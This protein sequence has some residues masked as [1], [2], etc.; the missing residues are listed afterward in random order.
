[1]RFGA[2]RPDLA[3]RS[4]TLPPAAQPRQRGN[5]L[6]SPV[7]SGI[8]ERSGRTSLKYIKGMEK[9][10]HNSL[11]IPLCDAH[12]H[13]GNGAE[14]AARRAQGIR[15]ALCG[16]DP[17]NARLVEEM[18]AREALF[19]PTYGLHPWKTARFTVREMEPWLEKCRVIGEIGLDSVWCDV[20]AHDQRAAFARQLDIAREMGKR[21]LLH[22]KGCEEEI[23]RLVSERRVPCVVHWYSCAHDMEKY[24]A[25][26]CAFTFALSLESDEHE[27]R[28]AAMVP[29]ERILVESDGISAMEWVKGR[30]IRDAEYEAGLR[31]IEALLAEIRGLSPEAMHEQ[32]CANYRRI[33]LR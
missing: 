2:W 7:L 18:C 25:L 31:Q 12:A 24:I 4:A 8:C 17:E 14:T 26:G 3:E 22:T 9:S 19:T 15:T 20:P 30:P 28:L 11:N 27:R 6:Y 21:V 29:L 23:A 10:R 5:D 32:I 13:P 16:T 1:M 33:I